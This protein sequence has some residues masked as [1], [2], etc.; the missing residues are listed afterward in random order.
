MKIIYGNENTQEEHRKLYA[1]ADI[2]EEKVRLLRSMG[3]S[4]KLEIISDG[5][6]LVWKFLQ[7]NWKFCEKQNLK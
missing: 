1:I 4:I 3:H 6:N 2:T 7:E 5:R